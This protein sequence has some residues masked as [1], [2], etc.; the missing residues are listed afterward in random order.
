MYYFVTQTGTFI[1]M[2]ASVSFSVFE[3]GYYIVCKPGRKQITCYQNKSHSDEKG[4]M[5]VNPIT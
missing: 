4:Q 1:E 5:E 2:Y 3:N